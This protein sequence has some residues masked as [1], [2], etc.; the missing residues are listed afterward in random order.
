LTDLHKDFD[1][2]LEQLDLDAALTLSN[3]LLQ[4]AIYLRNKEL[5][6]TKVDKLL[7]PIKPNM[8]TDT[9]IKLPTGKPYIL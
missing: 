8:I 6:N 1:Q 2:A 3:I 7:K 9:A 4:K 5:R